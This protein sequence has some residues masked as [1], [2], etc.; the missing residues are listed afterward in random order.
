MVKINIVSNPYEKKIEFK[1]Y[2]SLTG[3]WQDIKETNPNSKLREVETDNFFLPF[4]IKKIMSTIAGEYYM[5]KE[6]VSVVFSGT[7]EEYQQV[8]EVCNDEDLKDKIKLSRDSIMLENAR[9]ILDDT[10]EVFFKVKPVI[11]NIVKDN[12]VIMKDLNKVSDALEDIIPICVFGNY[13]SGKST[14]INALIGE[15]ILPSGGDPITAKIYEIHQGKSNDEAR[16]S[17]TYRKEDFLITFEG[18]TYRLEKGN[19]DCDLVED[20]KTAVDAVAEDGMCAMVGAALVVINGFE[21]KD[22]SDIVI[23]DIITLTVPFSKDGVLGQSDDKFVIFDTPG[24]NSNSNADHSAVLKQAME[25]FSNGIPVWISVYES[26]DSEDNA[27]LCNDILSIKAL[28]N[29]FTMIISNK[30]DGSDLDEEKF[31]DKKIDEILNY[32]SIKK[33]YSSGI[34]FVS[35][36]MGLASKKK[37]TFSDKHYRKI[38]RSQKEMYENPED[39]DYISLYKYNIMPEQMK[40]NAIRYSKNST[41][42]I[43]ANSGLLCIEMEMENFASR[44]SAYNKCQM[45]YEFLSGIIDE[46][47]KKIEDKISRR[48]KCR[49][50]FEEK[51]DNQEQELINEITE[52]VKNTKRVLEKQS[53]ESIET[54]TKKSVIKK[55]KVEEFQKMDDSIRQKNSDESALE[56]HENILKDSKEYMIRHFKSN[57]RN[58]FK[59]DFFKNVVKLGTDLMEDYEEVSDISDSRDDEFKKANE[60]SSD[61][62]IQSVIDKYKSETG[63]AQSIIDQETKRYWSEKAD[64]EKERLTDLITG[65]ENLSISKRTEIKEIIMNYE[66]LAFEDDAD[67]LF[68][69]ERFLRGNLFGFKFFDTQELNIRK[70]TAVYNKTVEK[71]AFEMAGLINRKSE[72]SFNNWLDNL[73]V[74]IEMNI[75]EYNSD[76]KDLKESI[77]DET[78]TINELTGNKGFIKESFDAITSMMKWKDCE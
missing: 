21:K 53:K 71:N 64:K 27:E 40:A 56:A 13:S 2:D 65:S 46:T 29:R 28:D 43:Y 73:L 49:K 74:V 75:T 38:Y 58:L 63:N 66:P 3:N 68:I 17:F 16:I 23:G 54:F 67:S 47:D 35:S 15:E 41:N 59:G 24:S 20:V 25:N 4:K 18:N 52:D 22:A 7:L 34:F 51:F 60:K 11:E 76:L 10:K 9:H 6:T 61:T 1:T 50:E 42:I 14:F 33:M 26:I 45:V 12:E 62:M 8:V 39:E 69:K 55:R 44:Y 77:Q 19:A 57:G 48:E 72:E 5:G 36:I 30:A 32:N 37:G 78:D 70:I 31:T